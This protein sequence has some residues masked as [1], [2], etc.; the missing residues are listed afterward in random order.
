MAQL[1]GNWRRSCMCAEVKPEQVG[2]T[3]TVMGWVH[4]RRDLGQLMFL[5]LRDRTGMVQVV[6]DAGKDA[7]LAEKASVIRGEYVLAVKGIVN[8]RTPENIN[9]ALKTGTI[10]IEAKELRILNES[11]TPPFHLDEDSVSEGFRLKYRYYDLR[12][13]ALQR[14]LMMKHAVTRSIREYLDNAGFIDLETPILTQSTPEGARDYL[15]PSRVFPGSFFAL[16]QS[17]QIFKQLLM[18]A[19]FDRYYQ[20]AKCFRDEDLRADRQPEFQQIDIEMSFVGEEEVYA[21][22][23]GMYKKLF[24]D[25]LDVDLPTPW[26]RLPF[27]DAMALY[28]SDKPDT[29][30]DMQIIQ[31]S[32]L[33]KDCGFSV[34]TEAIAQ[35]GSVAAINAKGAAKSFTRKELDGLTEVVKTYKAKGLAY[36]L[37]DGQNIRSTITKFM[38]P[39]EIHVIKARCGVEDGDALF[40]V[41]DKTSVTQRALGQLRLELGKR[42]NLIDKSKWNFLWITEFPL[43][44]YNEEEGRYTA[45]HHPFCSPLDEDIDL[46][47]TAPEKVR[48]KSYDIVLNGVELASGSI[49][50]H[51]GEVQEKIFKALGFTHEQAW[52]RFGFMLGAFKFGAPPHGGIAPGLDRTVM[53]MAG[54]DSIRDVVAFPKIQSSA[55]PMTGAPGQVDPKQLLEL[56]IGVL[57]QNEA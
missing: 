53:M 11:D 4:R 6:F 32:D 55:C 21:I 2:E 52:E 3:V 1:L 8:A 19:G 40:F 39:D 31:V 37:F 22:A 51:S 7:A 29:R 9:P 18:V 28:G 47:E 20:I 16:P 42:L 34:F 38:S 17:P 35:G 30:F 27:R 14:V 54:T 10:E 45:Q 48:C 25:V 24:K 50:I 57:P 23:E 33:V 49:R 15:V 5:W 41:A 36:M 43:L 56:G 46:L 44:E 12:R 13:P 26:P